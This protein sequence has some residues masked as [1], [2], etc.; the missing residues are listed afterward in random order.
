MPSPRG[1]ISAFVTMLVTSDLDSFMR[2]G[3]TN[4]CLRGRKH[5]QNDG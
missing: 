1:L 2:S 5:S 3:R 4:R